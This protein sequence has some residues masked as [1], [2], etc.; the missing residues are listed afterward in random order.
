MIDKLV[1]YAKYWHVKNYM[2]IEDRITSYNVCY[3]KLLR[4]GVAATAAATLRPTAAA[5]A[6][7]AQRTGK[8]IEIKTYLADGALDVLMK[9]KNREKHD[10]LVLDLLKQ[11]EIV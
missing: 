1:P 3:T 11:A 7:V 6:Q 9:E 8:T 5:L 2:R 4:I 10:R